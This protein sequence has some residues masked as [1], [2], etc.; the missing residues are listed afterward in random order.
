MLF[1]FDDHGDPFARVSDN[2]FNLQD[3]LGISDK[4]EGYPVNTLIKTEG[5]I[6]LI[7]FG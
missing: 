3:V 5:E 4:T 2:L 7:L 1:N 6:Y